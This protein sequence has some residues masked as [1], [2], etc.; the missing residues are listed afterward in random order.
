[1]ANREADSIQRSESY[2]R[3]ESSSSSG[4]VDVPSNQREQPRL[5]FA[6]SYMTVGG[7]APS[8]NGAALIR[9]LEEDRD[10]RRVYSTDDASFRHGMSSWQFNAAALI[11]RPTPPLTP[12]DREMTG[13]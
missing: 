7:G 13:R 9:A 3:A 4:D 5:G 11:D 12:G 10:P 6:R 2:F 8:Q 1:M